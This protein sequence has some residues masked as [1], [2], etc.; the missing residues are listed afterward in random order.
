M[1]DVMC[2][3]SVKKN[4]LISTLKGTFCAQALLFKSK[5]R[6]LEWINLIRDT[7]LGVIGHTCYF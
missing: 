7:N 2:V 6:Y 3:L 4:H 5:T 1:F